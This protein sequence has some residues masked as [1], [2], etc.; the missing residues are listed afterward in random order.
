[1][2]SSRII[3]RFK[4]LIPFAALFVLFSCLPSES[5]ER[6]S[7][8]VLQGATLFD[9]TGSEAIDNSVVV[10]REDRIACVGTAEECE[11][12]EGGRRVDLS[13]KYITPGLIDAHVHFFQTGFFDSRP[14][15]LDL[16]DTYPYG[17][18]AAY[19]KRNPQRYYDAYLCSG[20]TGVYDVGG[21]SWSIGFQESAE[22]NPRAPH[23]S[24]SGP[25]LT[26]ATMDLLNTPSDKTL[27]T[28]DSEETGREAVR[29]ISSLGSTGIKLWQLDA[30]SESYMNYVDAIADEAEKRDNQLIVHATTLAQARAA[31]EAGAELL[32]HSVSD[33][34]LD[35]AFI[36][37]TRKAGTIYTP[38]L[39]VG[40]GYMRAY[41]AAAGI[42][43][44]QISD[45]NGCVDTKTKE[46]LKNASQFRDHPDFTESFRKRLR[47]FDLQEDRV[48]ETAAENLKKV[49]EA[50]IPIAVGTD[51]GNP[52]TLHGV[53]IYEELE[54]MQRAGIPAE[55]L[56]VMATQ[57]GAKAMQRFEDI[58]TLEA[59]KKADLIVLDKDPSTDIANMRT[60]ERLMRDGLMRRVE[61]I[62]QAKKR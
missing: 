7:T 20:V 62:N 17:E 34:L 33:T 35:R 14:D 53:S 26:P 29:Y 38:T 58:G 40:S 45:P 51:A 27:V 3:Q 56:I 21:F 19:Q 18:V 49:Y 46:L 28:I 59:G 24:A 4:V 6:D 13:G 10:I 11:I 55:E 60:I 9:G 22:G 50:G 32:V 47:N 37:Q 8:V 23:V 31:V 39:I 42:A 48:D 41:R 2:I 36:E 12:P 5:G 44:Y 52:G 57:N 16:R 43:P 54:A 25:L 15:A 30:D 1:M 61:E